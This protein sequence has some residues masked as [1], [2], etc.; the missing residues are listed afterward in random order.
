MSLIIT[1]RKVLLPLSHMENPILTP[2]SNTYINKNFIS[3]IL[4]SFSIIFRVNVHAIEELRD[5]SRLNFPPFNFHTL[6]SLIVASTL[7]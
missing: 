6:S 5:K 4:M 1:S 3:R 2:A 7:L